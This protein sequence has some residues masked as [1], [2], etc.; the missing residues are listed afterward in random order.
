MALAGTENSYKPYDNFFQIPIFSDERNM[1]TPL[2]LIGGLQVSFGGLRARAMCNCL[3]VPPPRDYQIVRILPISQW[4]KRDKMLLFFPFFRLKLYPFLSFFAGVKCVFFEY[5]KIK[6]Y[7]LP[8]INRQYIDNIFFLRNKNSLA[9]DNNIFSQDQEK[10]SIDEI[11]PLKDETYP[12]KDKI[13]PLK[14]ETYPLKDETCPSKDETYPLKDET[15]PLKDETY[16]SKDETCPL[17]DETCPSKDETYPSKDE[18]YP[19]KDETYPL[20][21]E[22]YP[23]KDET[24]PSKDN[25]EISNQFL[26]I[27]TNKN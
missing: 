11:Y 17:K 3:V 1:S 27:E 8:L 22:T 13:Y 25:F 5:F 6:N 20:K 21:D 10:F 15:C 14:D 4:I 18:T 24:C 19:S 2:C 9:R 26:I 23:L 16:P 12:L 7:T